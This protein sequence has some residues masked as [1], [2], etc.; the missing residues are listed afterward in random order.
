MR[1]QRFVATL[2]GL[3]LIGSIGPASLATAQDL[4]PAEQA[5]VDRVW[6][7]YWRD[8]APFYIQHAESYVCVPGYD[9]R[10]P[11]ST[12]VSASDY[13]RQTARQVEYRDER[14]RD[15]TRVEAKP[16]D[17]AT[18]AV[19]ALPAVEVGTYGHIHS[20]SVAEIV[21]GQTVILRDVW[22]VDTDQVRQEKA[23]ALEA[24]TREAW[25]EVENRIRRARDG[26][27][28]NGDTIAQEAGSQRAFV[29]WA[30]ADREA[31][32]RRQRDRDFSRAQW[33]I[34]G[35]KTES[36]RTGQRW[37]A[38]QTLQLVIVE[39][40]DREIIAVPAAR[41][42]S[43]LSELDFLNC[44]E[45]RSITKAQFVEMMNEA[46][47][48]HDRDYMPFLLATLEGDDATVDVAEPNRGG[49]EVELA[50]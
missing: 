40:T 46:R 44:L 22:L 32:A 41:I 29:E 10:L 39:V 47:R 5:R 14:G 9:R 8:V 37:P 34:E 19:Q 12:G 17:E 33:R 18:A 21:D 36:L 31:L 4:D 45:A 48:E 16:D 35:F 23:A 42:G 43:G 3:A 7:R 11:S 50:E 6:N 2:M 28:N 25:S 15:Q 13:Q 26:R 49:G 24:V 27:R 38:G 30:F 20:G 1:M